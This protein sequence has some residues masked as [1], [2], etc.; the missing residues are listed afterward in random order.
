LVVLH[1]GYT[2]GRIKKA[3]AKQEIFEKI[4]FQSF[5]LI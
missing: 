5:E 2:T 3:G 4:V 1:T